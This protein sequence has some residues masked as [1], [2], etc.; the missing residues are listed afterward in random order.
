MKIEATKNKSKKGMG[1]SM[2]DDELN[3][4]DGSEE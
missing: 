2:D 4:S 3:N 1:G